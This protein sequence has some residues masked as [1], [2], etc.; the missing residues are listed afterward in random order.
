MQKRREWI[1]IGKEGK[2]ELFKPSTMKFMVNSY[3]RMEE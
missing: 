2:I 3:I 1:T